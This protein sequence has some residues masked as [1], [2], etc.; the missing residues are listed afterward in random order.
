MTNEKLIELLPRVYV[1]SLVL[2]FTAGQHHMVLLA[3]MFYALTHTL[4]HTGIA[5]GGQ[6]SP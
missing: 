2:L 5:Q 6:G 3:G 1:V 4:T